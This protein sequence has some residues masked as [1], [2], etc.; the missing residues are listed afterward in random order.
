MQQAHNVELL[1]YL[2]LVMNT[3][4]ESGET[5]VVD[6]TVV[7]FK[8]VGYLRPPRLARTFCSTFA[9]KAGL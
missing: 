9:A 6:F 7:L 5:A 1:N 3:D 8:F 2:N 4:P